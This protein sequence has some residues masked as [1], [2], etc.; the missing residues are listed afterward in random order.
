M[1]V[2]PLGWTRPDHTLALL[3]QSNTKPPDFLKVYAKR[4]QPDSPGLIQPLGQTDMG[5]AEL[6]QQCK[7]CIRSQTKPNKLSDLQICHQ[8]Y[9]RR[10]GLTK[11]WYDIAITMC[12]SI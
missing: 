3:D 6:V 11:R 8:S 12:D 5:N 4:V 7:Y 1:F 9:L 10:T 2:G